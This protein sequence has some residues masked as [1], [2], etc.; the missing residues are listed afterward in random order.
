MNSTKNFLALHS[1][2]AKHSTLAIDVDIAKTLG[3]DALEISANKVEDY[4]AA[5]HSE[6][7]LNRLLDGFVIPGIGYLANIERIGSEATSLFGDAERLFGIAQAA[8]ARG[9]Q[10]L[11]G[12]IDVQAVIDHEKNVPQSR[13]AGLLGATLQEQLKLTAKNIAKLGEMAAE[14]GLILYLEALSWTPL[15]SMAHQLELIDRSERDNVKVL[16]DYWHCYTSGETPDSIASLDRAVI[17]GV[18]VCDSLS[19]EGGI[20]NETILRD[21]PTGKGVL[22]LRDWTDAVKATGYVGWWSG[23]LFCRKEQ[24]E[25]SYTVAARMNELLESLIFCDDINSAQTHAA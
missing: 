10:I 14:F 4:L 3:L 21:V 24:Q 18:H 11:T 16:I 15:K 1:T 25:N 22:N 7:D 5:G 13:Y 23:E 2:V 6:R 12:P 20:P 9:V 8:G 19:F 17:Y